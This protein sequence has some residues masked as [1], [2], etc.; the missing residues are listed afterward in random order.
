[1]RP[2]GF[3]ALFGDLPERNKLGLCSAAVAE[4]T[5]IYMRVRQS[6]PES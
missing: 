1:M 5:H 6:V 2:R 3:D 4:V